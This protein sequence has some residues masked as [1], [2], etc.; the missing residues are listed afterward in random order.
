MANIFKI[1]GKVYTTG[2]TG[3]NYTLKSEYSYI[4]EPF[5][6]LQELHLE[7]N[8]IRNDYIKNRG[9][10]YSEI[11]MDAGFIGHNDNNQLIFN[12]PMMRS[13]GITT[14]GNDQY[15]EK[16]IK[17]MRELYQTPLE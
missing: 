7:F 8:R 13:S 10:Q 17:L 6:D 12:P 14:Q 11:G 5:T 4:S 3:D 9:V 16:R 1:I 2:A 15:S